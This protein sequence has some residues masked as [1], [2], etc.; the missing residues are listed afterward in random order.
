MTGKAVNLG[1]DIL[2]SFM[3]S[4]APWEEI[5]DVYLQRFTGYIANRIFG[6]HLG[7]TFDAQCYSLRTVSA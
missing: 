7:I 1:K 4:V 5:Q 3:L 6:D 2:T